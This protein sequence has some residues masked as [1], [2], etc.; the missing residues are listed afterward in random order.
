V[1][2]V[3]PASATA[4]AMPL[5]PIRDPRKRAEDT[6]VERVFRGCRRIRAGLAMPPGAAPVSERAE[7]WLEASEQPML[8]LAMVAVAGYLAE[9]SGGFVALGVEQ[10]WA[11]VG[12]ALD[13]VFLLDLVAKVAILRGRY[14]TSPWFVVDFV[15]TVPVLSALSLVPSTFA[16][17]RFV[18]AFRVLR[19]LRTLRGLRSL[20]MLQFA[21]SNAE[22]TEQR[23]FDRALA[24]SVTLYTVGFLGL[25]TWGRTHPQVAGADTPEL[26]LVLGSLLG[27]LLALVVA[28][29]QI[30]ALWSRQMRAL[31]D[32]ALPLQVAEHLMR[33]P[34]AYDKTVRG[35]ATVIF[36]DI[37]GFTA[38]VEKLALDEVKT[39]LEAAL[40]VVVEAH[41]GQDLI[42]DKFIGDSVM[43]FRG[44]NLVDGDASDHAYRVVRAALVG[45]RALRER[46]DPWFSE[47]KVGGA[48]ATDALIG[49]FGTSRRLSYTILGDR[50]NLAARLEGSCNALGV[51]NLFCDLTHTLVA[52]RPGIWWRRVG[53]MRVQGREAR[54]QVWEAFDEEIPWLPAFEA[55]LVR[56]EARDFAGAAAGFAALAP[57]GAA[58]VYREL[59]EKLAADPPDAD[60]TPVI[61][62]RK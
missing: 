41:V 9:L 19:V 43:S 22:T 58:A 45:A 52:G 47:V 29:F 60:W 12:L 55:A 17:L 40:D 50:V 39:H 4:R 36:C 57:D 44:G 23:L 14:L 42:I 46:G 31:L 11:P 62:T 2:G 24:V 30:P 53:G 56:Y 61:R 20:R 38:T 16:G 15:C 18:R 8:L 1:V 26:F 6:P 37:K 33:N 21:T 51:R 35:A 54:E 59:C 32:V 3:Q 28:R 13:L 25:V 48:S 7:Q 27:M 49:T 34:S 5:G 10:A